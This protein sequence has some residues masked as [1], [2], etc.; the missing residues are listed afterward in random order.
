MIGGEDFRRLR[1]ALG[2]ALALAC[3]GE[4]EAQSAQEYAIKASFITKFLEFVRWPDSSTQAGGAPG[5]FVVAVLGADPFHD[6]LASAFQNRAV[7][8]RP[9][10]VTRIDRL[11]DLAQCRVVF[12]PADE[13]RRVGSVV[14]WASENRALTIGDAEGFA[15]L[16]VIINFYRQDEKV[17]FEINAKA[18]DST[19]LQISSLLL[20]VAR[21]VGQ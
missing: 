6:E 8:G 9:V 13:R 3:A 15:E 17:R 11:E 19:G 14:R 21:I 12:I 2:L 1:T 7:H 16:G 18:A 10:V 4:A 20:K 5:A